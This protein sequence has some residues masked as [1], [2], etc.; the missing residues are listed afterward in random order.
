MAAA[1]QDAAPQCQEEQGRAATGGYEPE[2][3]RELLDESCAVCMTQLSNFDH[4]ASP[5]GC[6]HAFCLP[7]LRE[8]ANR[9]R[10]CPTCRASFRHLRAFVVD[11][12]R[13]RANGADVEIEEQVVKLPACEQHGDGDSDGSDDVDE[14]TCSRCRSGAHED[15]LLICDGCSRGWH[16]FC[17]ELDGVPAG[18]WHCPACRP[19]D[20][21][22]SVVAAVAERHASDEE[23][24]VMPQPSARERANRERRAQRRATLAGVRRVRRLV[25][26]QERF[27]RAAED[28]RVRVPR[29]SAPR[30]TPPR[31]QL[32]ASLPA[33]LDDGSLR[34]A[35]LR[36]GAQAAMFGGGAVTANAMPAGR[37]RDLQAMRENWAA[38]QSGGLNWEA[39]T[40]PRRAQAPPGRI[41]GVPRLGTTAAEAGEG[42]PRHVHGAVS[43]VR[44]PPRG[45]SMLDR[46]RGIVTASEA[47]SAAASSDAGADAKPARAA[48]RRSSGRRGRR[49]GPRGRPHRGRRACGSPAARRRARNVAAR[50]V[51]RQRG[52]GAP[53]QPRGGARTREREA[54][55]EAEA[56]AQPQPLRRVRSRVARR[57]EAAPR[58]GAPGRVRRAR[59]AVAVVCAITARR[60]GSA[61]AVPAATGERASAST[62]AGALRRR[63]R[64]TA[65][66][67]AARGPPR[68]GRR[69]A[70]GTVVAR[71]RPVRRALAPPSAPPPPP[72]Y[73]RQRA[74][75][76]ARSALGRPAPTQD[77]AF[78]APPPSAPP[79]PRSGPMNLRIPAN[80]NDVP[81]PPPAPPSPPPPAREP[82][83][84]PPAA[85]EPAPA[86]TY[87][88]EDVAQA[89]E[90]AFLRARNELNPRFKKGTLSREAFKAVG[91]AATH[92]LVDRARKAGA[93]GGLTAAV[94]ALGEEEVRSIV[95]GLL[96]AERAKEKQ[97]RG[98]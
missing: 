11:Q 88:D 34:C 70:A 76:A 98:K 89:K 30:P 87:G 18:A 26:L 67:A 83:P 90:K 93:T 40:A 54:G 58:A 13:L 95:G 41:A 65:A 1:G 20:F 32:G 85:A 7:D 38:L 8:W 4:I 84:P 36:G 75:S 14:L 24:E 43:E 77:P 57:A 35:G 62:S 48:G 61:R 60:S 68:L 29:P 50:S 59:S 49:C 47:R 15:R 17:V 69:G 79:P 64:G 97:R 39:I 66:A 22:P 45:G 51:P 52:G 12:I 42:E 16:T 72:A 81:A 23:A 73:A 46:L 80:L 91:R 82:S 5:D 55:A 21:A 37:A 25:E 74:A 31:V 6:H 10:S 44:A 19:T 96:A 53:A 2:Q 28:S 56:E 71:R 3:C 86:P 78:A 27:R 33:P 9:S 92:A 94:A 63:W